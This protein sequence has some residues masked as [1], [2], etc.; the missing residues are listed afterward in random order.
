MV[1]QTLS[2]WQPRAP[3]A[4]AADDAHQI[5]ANITGYFRILEDWDRKEKIGRK[6]TCS[7][8]EQVDG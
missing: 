7:T 6:L 3:R 2:I 8:K 5:I 4:L 1:E